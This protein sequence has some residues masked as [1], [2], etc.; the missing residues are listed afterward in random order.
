[1]KRYS[2]FYCTTLLS[3]FVISNLLG[4]QWSLIDPSDMR[5]FGQRDIVPRTYLTYRIDHVEMKSRLWTAP[6]EFSSSVRES[7]VMITVALADGSIDRFRMARYDMMESELAESYPDIRTF[8]G[9]SVSDPYRRIRADWT[10]EGFRAV[11]SDL[12]GKTYIDPFQRGDLSTRIVYYKKDFYRDDPWTCEVFGDDHEKEQDTGGS[13]FGDCQFRTYRLA[14]ATTGE[15]SNY[16]GATSSAQSA[17]VMSAVVTAINRVNDVYEADFTVRL[18]LV[19]NTDAVFYY[20]PATDPY[21]NNNGGAMLDQNIATLNNVIGNGN[22]DLGHVFSTGGGGVAYLNAICNN[23]YKAGGVTGLPNPVGDPFYIDYVAHEMGHQFGSNHTF[24]STTGSCGGGNRSSSS[25]FEPGSGSTIMA[26]AG[27]CG[28]HNLQPNS[29]AYMHARSLLTINNRITSTNCHQTLAFNNIPP[30]VTAMPNCTIPISTPFVLTAIVTDPDG[31]PLTYCWEHY[32][33]ETSAT[34]PP[35]AN[36]NDGPMFRSF[37][38]TASPSRYFPRLQDLVNNINPMWEVLPSVTRNLTFRMTVRDF[39]GVAGCTE[40][41]EVIVRTIATAGPFVVTSQNTATTWHAGGEE[42]ITWNVANTNASP[43]NCAEVDIYLSYDG[44]FTYPVLLA[45]NVPNSGSAVVTIPNDTYTTTARV[46]VKAAANIFFDINNVNITIDP[47]NSNYTLSVDNDSLIVCTNVNQVQILVSVGSNFGYTDPVSLSIASLPGGVSAVFN[48]QV[49]IPGNTSTLTISNLQNLNGVFNPVIRAT[50]TSGP[51]DVILYLNLISPNAQVALLAP[52]DQAEDIPITPSLSWSG[53]EQF[54]SFDLEIAADPAFNNVVF[55]EAILSAS[56]TLNDFVLEMDST[57][58]WRIRGYS[59][60]GQSPWS[61]VWSFNTGNC[62]QVMSEDL[63]KTIVNTTTSELYI[64]LDFIVGD[65]DVI[66]LAG[67]HT[68]VDDIIATLIAP[69][70]SE[71]L[72]W[73]QPCG[74]ED[75]FH[76]NFDD[77]APNSNWPCPP[78]DGLTYKPDN[79][80][81]FFNGKVG[82]GTWKLRINDAFP[83]EDNGVLQSWGLR[84]CRVPCPLN[85]FA[86]SG[87]GFGSLRSALEC[88]VPNDTIRLSASLSGQVIDIGSASISLDKDVVIMAEGNNIVITG[89]GE[90][91]FHIG[92]GVN[93]SMIGFEV[94]AADDSDAMAIYNQGTLNLFDIK[95]GSN[96]LVPQSTVIENSTGAQLFINGDCVVGQ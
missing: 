48:P 81:A 5:S 30:M 93:V 6:Q 12:S 44:G 67:T 25:A 10:T 91:I 21:T 35:A 15:Y 90:R 88:A 73:N 62:F 68:W 89:I 51:Q 66:Q 38:P 78:T 32:D 2:L 92:T 50:S 77:D 70:N 23:S 54:S 59:V 61:A 1:M 45:D 34:E 72:I 57:Y 58:Y 55:S 80:L 56:F 96:A 52:A 49:V 8:I 4:Q 27:I 53:S 42:T 75:N 18:I 24:N 74:S 46:M 16:F 47:P 41:D 60:C 84:F 39:H 33:L 69:D 76:I 22:F 85:V 14:Q 94:M 37:M 87:D 19:N 82:T 71:R 13:R 26:Y 17:L 43:I 9:V 86:D 64:P 95:V 28:A 79:T 40:H 65:I 3:L 7:E 29:D 11:I 63:P 20:N 83:S 36:D 31:D